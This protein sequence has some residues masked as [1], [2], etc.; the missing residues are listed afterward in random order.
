MIAGIFILKQECRILFLVVVLFVVI[1]R[2]ICC[3]VHKN[4]A[5]FCSFGFMRSH[6]ASADFS[7]SHDLE[8]YAK[9][10]FHSVHD[11][12]EQTSS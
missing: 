12:L 9:F 5:L 3:V 4:D 7:G 2:I 1:P 10:P 6:L 11:L 8:R